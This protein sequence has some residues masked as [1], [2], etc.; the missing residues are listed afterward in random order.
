MRQS[1]VDTSAIWFHGSSEARVSKLE[2]PSFEHPFYV[3]SD[4]HYAMAFC[5]KKQSNTG[6]YTHRELKFTPAEQ[7]YVY[8]V[9]LKPTIKVFDFRDHETTEFVQVF[10]KIMD[11]ELV[12]W[13]EDADKTFNSADI[14]EFCA[15]IDVSILGPLD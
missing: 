6:D 5:T 2:A 7:N 11:L 12:K 1:K 3:T 9:T 4:L 14:Y 15:G 10:S 13:V 8:A